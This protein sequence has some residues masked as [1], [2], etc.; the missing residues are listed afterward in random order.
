MALLRSLNMQAV[1]GRGYAGSRIRTSENSTSRHLGEAFS[2]VPHPPKPGHIAQRVNAIGFAY[3]TCCTLQLLVARQRRGR[4]FGIEST[5]DA[6]L[7]KPSTLTL[8]FSR[9][10]R[11]LQENQ[12]ADERT[13]TADLISLRVCG[14]GLLGV[15]GVCKCRINKPF[16]V[17]C[18]AHCC[19]A[20][21]PG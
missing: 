11:V 9:F 17:P 20:L 10:L 6:L 2:T 12:R 18:I 15:A 7:T 5:A 8:W 13:R 1:P 3:A 19:R 16:L 21:H 14:Q 4:S